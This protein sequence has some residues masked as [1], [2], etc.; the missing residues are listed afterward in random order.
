MGGGGGR[1]ASSISVVDE[2]QSSV[3]VVDESKSSSLPVRSGGNSE[4]ASGVHF[5]PL[6]PRAASALSQTDRSAT[7]KTFTADTL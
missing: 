3:S 2:S 6:P 7:L 5:L 4:A 1:L